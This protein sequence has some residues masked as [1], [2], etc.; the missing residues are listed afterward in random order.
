MLI[1]H[2]LFVTLD[3]NLAFAHGMS[4]DSSSKLALNS[5][6][7]LLSSLLYKR[8]EPTL[9]QHDANELIFFASLQRATDA[10][11]R[12]RRNGERER[13]RESSRDSFLTNV[14]DTRRLSSF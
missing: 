5:P 2:L 7:R 6:M 13:K 11:W 14:I 10:S 4:I 1:D 12:G 3:G 9:H 8:V